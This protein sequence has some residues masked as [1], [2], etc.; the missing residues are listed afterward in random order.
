[1]F[2]KHITRFLTLMAIMVVSVGFMSGVGE[3]KDKIDTNFNNYY[4][5]QNVSDLNIK[6]ESAFLP[7]SSNAGKNKQSLKDKFGE[8]NVMFAFCNDYEID[9]NIYRVYL[10]DLENITVN[11][12][13]L[14]S[15]IL[16][17]VEEEILV[18]AGSK[19][20]KSF[21][22][23]QEVTLDNSQLNMLAGNIKTFHVSGIVQSPMLLIKDKEPSF[24]EGKNIDYCIYLNRPQNTIIT[25][26]YIALPDR[27]LFGAFSE[28][29]K[30]TINQLKEE[31]SSTLSV[32]KEQILSLYENYGIFSLHAYASK[33]G[34]I[35]IIFVIFFL[36]VTALVVFSTMTRLLDEERGQIACLKTLGFGNFKIL[37]RYLLFIFAASIFGGA[38]GLPVG[39]FLTYFIYASFDMQY[40]MPDFISGVSFGYFG[41]TLGIILCAALVVTFFTGL[42]MVRQKPA[43]L[44]TPKAPKAGKKVILERIPFFW[45]R[46]SFKYKSCLRNV[47][48]FKSRFFMTVISLV[49]STVLVLSGLG[50]LDNTIKLE[51]G[52]ALIMLAIALI[53][54]A[55][56]LSALVI[57]NLA[58]IN[59][60]ERN[61]EIATLMVLGYNN[62]EVCGYIYREIYIMSAVGAL[63]GIP[64]AYWFMSFVFG[65]IDFGSVG[66]VNWFTWIIGPILMMFFTF[67]STILLRKKIVKTDMNASLKSLE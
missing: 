42:K 3:V 57:Y 66:D 41:I 64:L 60:S 36:L 15:G 2:R 53:A 65:F 9:G 30:A 32:P 18:A 28:N 45:N 7:F 48:L 59:I 19:G 62:K 38:V 34:D 61:R 5:S 25:D 49:G 44:L 33:V 31:L 47:L 14:V 58:N 22:I 20:L 35:A 12:L 4:I 11:K 43:K 21:N 1:M 51:A 24:I 29:Y 54:F 16:P 67:L 56:I 52:A 17:N 46:L 40:F 63:L 6:S 10:M 37:S 39:I 23:G 27:A 8:G 55:G 26:A 13:T 50:L